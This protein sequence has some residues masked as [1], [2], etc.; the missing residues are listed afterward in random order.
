MQTTRA[1]GRTTVLALTLSTAAVFGATSAAACDGDY[2]IQAGDTLGAIAAKCNT[3]VAAL[4]EANGVDLRTLRLGQVLAI[5]AGSSEGLA[6]R[7]SARTR[8]DA[9][10]AEDA[11]G[12]RVGPGDTIRSIAAD[13]G[14]PIEA[15]LAA[16]EG[17]DP[18]RMQIGDRLTVPGGDEVKDKL[19][20]REAERE[21]IERMATDYPNPTIELRQGEWRLTIDMKAEGLA[22]GEPVKVAIRG[23]SGDWVTL[24]EMPAD[25]EGELVARAR[26]PGE[27]ARERNL[28][29][30]M[31]RAGG[32]V[33]TAAYADGATRTASA[34]PAKPE[35]IEVMGKVVRG[36]G[37]SLLVTA[38]G[39]T[40]ALDGEALG[41][42]AGS[43]IVVSGA[44]GGSA[45]GCIG[46]DT[47]QVSAVTPTRG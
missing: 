22:P 16:N 31:E 35:S 6:V 26:I 3:S 17:I 14:V 44:V 41:V 27:L 1:L 39:D 15:L 46:H 12:Y 9:D 37:C 4:K 25:G 33:V 47:L 20:E 13:L 8:A 29:I 2:R 43:E 36:G 23:A 30:A 5:P 45:D 10:P 32:N 19:A 40:Y 18:R 11:A 38:S 21:R 42:S 7:E 34:E 24:G 28:E